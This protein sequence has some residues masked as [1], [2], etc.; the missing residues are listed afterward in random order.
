MMVEEAKTMS[1]FTYRLK[2]GGLFL[3]LLII[4]PYTRPLGWDSLL[5][6]LSP[7]TLFAADTNEEGKQATLSEFRVQAN[8]RAVRLSWEARISEKGQLT[9]EVYR[10]MANPNGEYTLVTSVNGTPEVTRYEY[11]DKAIPV[12]ENYFYKI[13]IP[14][15][16]EA[17]G[18][19]QARPP[20]SRPST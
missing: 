5:T 1:R 10:S 7:E 12:E 6:V 11:I 8:Y 19:L 13:K 18:P 14:E 4:I 3:A 9:F 20:F 16:K 2:A 15:T 17:F